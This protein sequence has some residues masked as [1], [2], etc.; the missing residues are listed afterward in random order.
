MKNFFY[1]I[2]GLVLAHF[3]AVQADDIE[4]YLGGSSSKGAAYVHLMLDYRPSVF[5][6]LCK[7]DTTCGQP[8]PITDECTASVCFSTEAYANLGTRSTG[9]TITRFDA[10]VAVMATILANPLFEEIYMSLVVSNFDNGGTILE[11]YKLLKTDAANLIATLQAIPE[12]TN[13]SKS[14][15][16]QPSETY[17]EWFSYINGGAVEFGTSTSNNF[18]GTASPDY[19]SSI[20]NVGETAYVSPFTSPSDCSKLF[21]ILLA[22]NSANQDDDLDTEIATD[23]SSDAA[24]KFEDMMEYMHASDTDLLSGVSGDQPLEKSWVISD[25]GSVGST[26]DWSAAGGSGSP[27]DIDDPVQLQVDFENIFKEVISVSS[28][29]V[30]ASVPVNVFNRT[31][32][33]DNL[34]IALFE[35]QSTIRWPGNVKKLKLKD[36]DVPADGEFDDIVDAQVPAQPGLESTGEDRG[37][38]QFDA[39]TFW[40]EVSEL[41]TGDGS[42]IPNNADGRVVARGGAGQKINGF[43]ESGS[44]VIG[45]ANSDTNARQ[46]FVEPS[47]I[48]NGGSNTFDDFDADNTT[49]SN[50]LTLLDPTSTI[51]VNDAKDLI[52]WARGQDVD[53]EDGDGD[54]DDP[55]S[56]ILGDA[57]HSRPLALNYGAVEGHTTSNPNIRLFFG[58]NDGL[59]HVV[60]NTSSSSSETGE[61]VFA[62]FPHEPLANISL[63]RANTEPSTKMRYGVDGP[64]VALIVDDDGDGN[65]EHPTDE[66]YVYFGM[67]RGGYSYYALD[68]SDPGDDPTLKWK[69]TQTSSGDFDELGLTFSK[70]VVGKVKFGSSITDVV[71]FAGGYNGGWN[72]SY[73]S[74]VGKD[75]NDNDDSVGNAVYIVNAR[76]GTLIWKAV[77][78][79]TANSSNTHYEHSGL[80]DSIPSEVAAVKNSSGIIH[81]L[82]VGDTG[83]AV[84]RIDLPPGDSGDHRKDNW[85][86]TKLAELGTDGTSTDRRFFHA[87]QVVE[88][89]DSAGDLDGVL[90]ASGNRADPNET[91]VTNYMFYIK[92]RLTVSGDSSVLSRSPL[93]LTDFADQTGCVAGNEVSCS[94]SLNNGWRVELEDSGEKGLSSALVDGGRVFFSSFVPASG[95]A[96]CAPTEGEGY[97]YIIQLAD[98]SASHQDQRKFEVGSGIPSDPIRVGKSIKPPGYPDDIP[99]DDPSDPGSGGCEGPLCSSTIK[100]VFDV[101]WREIGID[102]L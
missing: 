5:S 26:R 13:N 32:S 22:M 83:G 80:V 47:S 38:I 92:D 74:R 72:S 68:V 77:Q 100:P 46:V 37:R 24:F 14:H 54:A 65:I 12:P 58:T 91:S 17:Y 79:T 40:T 1:G 4:I 98:G 102:N 25:S 95:T 67:R 82:Y 85:F 73:T 51:S 9:D 28:T 21:S 3:G 78:G 61:E 71:I 63:R 60:E 36:T 52:R 99:P 69:V 94:T 2:A 33:L 84:W 62:F 57:I 75:L 16:L 76:T 35:A 29:F 97:L 10:F 44:N 50:L 101:Y 86:I 59:F 55:R 39:V 31:E 53:D 41:P 49:A 42:V 70:P 6:S 8:D 89:F 48:T 23:M 64:P 45:D 87:P 18:N 90:I 34:Y 30:S 43:I 81:R 7:Y 20:M 27:L 15:K 11:G 96:A 19:D 93:S 66:A 56:W 88:T